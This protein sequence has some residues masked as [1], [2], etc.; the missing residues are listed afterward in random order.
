[1]GAFDT[2]L[3]AGSMSAAMEGVGGSQRG[4]KPATAPAAQPQSV[5]M[6]D[7]NA[8][9]VSTFAPATQPV[10]AGWSSGA[11]SQPPPATRDEAMFAPSRS[12]VASA[13]AVQPIATWPAASSSG[14][15]PFDETA[16]PPEDKE[17]RCVCV[18][19]RV[20]GVRVVCVCVC[21]CVCVRA[22][23]FVCVPNC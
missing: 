15:V 4:N 14:F 21:V 18:Y 9:N 12:S 20:C 2:S 8:K 23:V 6:T 22:C 10:A 13:P 3:T 11:D 1:M 7:M 16:P 5:A 19:A 17:N